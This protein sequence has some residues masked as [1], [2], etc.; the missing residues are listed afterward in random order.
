MET[1]AQRFTVAA[2]PR[3]GEITNADYAAQYLFALQ[4][5]DATS[6][7][8]E[9][10]IRIR[11]LKAQLAATPAAVRP[12]ADALAATVT[13][14]E[15]QLYQIKNQGP[16]DKIANPIK[17][18]DRLAGLLALVD[19]GDG[20]PTAG[21]RAVA[22]GLLAQLN[23]HLGRLEDVTTRELRALNEKLVAVGAKPIAFR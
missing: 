8:N 2:D 16:K 4:M 22:A 20:A 6:A 13:E 1:H 18:N 15:A 21:Q 3:L 14:I 10:V 23:R 11:A 19:T 12:A 7:A 9:S 5:R 17:L